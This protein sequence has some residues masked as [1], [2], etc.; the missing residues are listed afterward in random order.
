MKKVINGT[1]YNTDTA[2]AIYKD[3]TNRLA[4]NNLCYY[5][6]K[7]YETPNKKLFLWGYGGPKTIFAEQ[8]G[9]FLVAGENIY[10]LTP[11]Q[12]EHI[13]RYGIEDIKIVD[14]K[15]EF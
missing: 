6:Y 11:Q 4:K 1:F 14:G 7:I 8:K 15:I 3:K 2:K 9:I 10:S 5:N 12:A 13:K